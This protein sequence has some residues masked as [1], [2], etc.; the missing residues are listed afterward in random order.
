VGKS[1]RPYHAP[2]INDG[3]A[4]DDNGRFPGHNTAELSLLSSYLP[5][6]GPDV[7]PEGTAQWRKDYYGVNLHDVAYERVATMIDGYCRRV[8]NKSELEEAIA[9]A[10]KSVQAGKTAVLNVM[11]PETVAF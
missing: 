4:V 5:G 6:R 8:E 1:I 10:L 2:V 9:E 3:C 11:M 7:Y